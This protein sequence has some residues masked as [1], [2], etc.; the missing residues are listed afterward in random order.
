VTE[1]DDRSDDRRRP[2]GPAWGDRADMP[3]ARVRRGS[4]TRNEESSRGAGTPARHRRPMAR[5]V[6]ARRAGSFP[7]C[8]WTLPARRRPATDGPSRAA[9]AP[10]RYSRVACHRRVRPPAG[11]RRFAPS[12]GRARP[13]EPDTRHPEDEPAQP[14]RTGPGAVG[15]VRRVRARYPHDDSALAT[16]CHRTAIRPDD[17]PRT[18]Y[19]DDDPLGDRPLAARSPDATSTTRS[20]TGHS[21]IAG[22]ARETPIATTRCST[23]SRSTNS[24][25]TTGNATAARSTNR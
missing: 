1:R 12:Q 22:I 6:G 15:L 4:R 17:R 3:W 13:V 16:H 10:H 23:T 24:H 2:A 8:R 18:S 11:S 20:A 7:R 21:G 14:C 25:G 5:T 19:L 9:P